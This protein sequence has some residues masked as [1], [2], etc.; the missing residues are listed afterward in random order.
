MTEEMVNTWGR[1]GTN[2]TRGKYTLSR[3]STKKYLCFGADF[4]NFVVTV[5]KR[6]ASLECRIFQNIPFSHFFRIIMFLSRTHTTHV[7]TLRTVAFAFFALVSFATLSAQDSGW[8]FGNRLIV[9]GGISTPVANF[10]ALPA[11]LQDLIP[12]DGKTPQGAAVMG[13]T[14]GLNDVFRFT[15]NLAL[16]VSLDANYNAFNNDEAARQL[17]N[18][19]LG[20]SLNGISLG[21]FSSLLGITSS[22]NAQAY[23]N[24]TLTGGIRYDL[25]VLAGLVNV[26]G[27]A[28]AGLF[29]GIA[30]QSEAKLGLNVLGV[31]A[32]ATISRPQASATAFAYKIGAGVLLFDRL[33]VGVNYVAAVPQY[34][35]NTTVNTVVTGLQ[36]NTTIPGL[37]TINTQTIVN[38][39]AGAIPAAASRYD[40]PTNV[41]QITIGYA[42]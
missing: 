27:N 28:Q 35:A 42:F 38:A 37:G 36:G 1:T 31:K 13:F 3:L 19:V 11:T 29:Y 34:I 8:T 22:Y 12:A 39:V 16:S 21:A 26:Y 4:V 25:P 32:D 2:H 9:Q 33:N 5:L 15:P 7:F 23:I 14:L 40:F 18:S 17:R 6:T 20:T 30:P 41:L 10:G 24:G